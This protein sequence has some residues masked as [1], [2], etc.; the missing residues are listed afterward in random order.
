MKKAP[1]TSYAMNKFW[2]SKK[3]G[4]T[5]ALKD[6][7]LLDFLTFKAEVAAELE[8]KATQPLTGG[9]RKAEID[10]LDN[11]TDECIEKVYA[12]LLSLY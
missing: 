7:N 11:F 2:M 3:I 12:K 10:A 6:A 1:H 8:E 9:Q 4:F 5:S